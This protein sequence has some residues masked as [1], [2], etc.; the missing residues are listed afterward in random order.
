MQRP[1]APQNYD[2]ICFLGA[3]THIVYGRD[4]DCCGELQ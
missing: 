2:T 3:E 4:A 1:V